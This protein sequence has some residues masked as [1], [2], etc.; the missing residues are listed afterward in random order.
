MKFNCG[1]T[2]AELRKIRSNWNSWFAWHPIRVGSKDCRWLETVER[3]APHQGYGRWQ[4]RS[5]DDS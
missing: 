5:L 4:Y 3:Y 1:L 2:Y